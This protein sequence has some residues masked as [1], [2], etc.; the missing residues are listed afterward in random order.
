MTIPLISI[1]C[2][3][4]NHAPFI[5]Q[6]L[7][8]FVMQKTNFPIEVLIHD[9]A[10][11]DGTA[12]IIREYEQK[13]PDIIKPIY[14]TENQYSKGISPSRIY[15][16][17]RIQGKYIAICE[18]DD[19]WTDEYKLQKQVDFLEANEDYS[20]CFH[21]VKVYNEE[22]GI[23]IENDI[24]QDVPDVTDIKLLATTNYI[25]T[26]S[27]IYRNN[28]QVF[29]DL[30]KFPSLG[31]GDYI[32]HMLFA[33]Y[34]KIKK[35][36]DTMAVYRM[37]KS[38]VWSSK[39]PEYT[40]SI[41]LRVLVAL[42]YHFIN[43]QEICSILIEQYKRVSI[44]GT[45]AF[46]KNYSSTGTIYFNTGNGYSEDEKESFSVIG[47][48]VE[49]SCQIPENT[50][51][52]RL[53]PV[54]N[55]GCVVSNLEILSRNGMVKHSAI[56]GFTDK[57]GDMVFVN[58]D[59][60]IELQ[61]VGQLL[62]IRYRIQLLSDFSF[63]RVLN[64][65]ID[66]RQERDDLTAERDGLII[67]RNNLTAERDG[68]LNSR[69]WRITKPLRKF[70]AFIRKNRVL[71]L[72]AKGLLSLKRN[73]IKKTLKKGTAYRQRQ[74]GIQPAIS[75]VSVAN[76]AESERLSQENEKFSKQIKISIITPLYNTPERFLREMIE[77]V[78]AQTYGNW[79]L[80][81]A[82][83][84][85]NEHENVKRICQDYAKKEKRIKYR[86][87]EE[88]HGISGNS[89]IAIEMSSG[90]YIGLLDHD[91]VL[92]PSALYEVMK[93]ICHENADFIYTDEATF[94]NDKITLR[95][96][97]PDYAID[98]LRSC[99]YICHFSVFSRNLMEQAGTF[100]SE[101]DGSQDYDLIF[102]YTDIASAIVHIPKLLY[103]W[104]SHENSAASDINTK[105]YAI[106]AGK[107][108][109]MEHLAKLGI[110]AKVES[111]IESSGFY[112]IIY[113][114]TGR[115]LVSIIIPN[116][117]NVSLLKKCLCSIMEKTTYD[118][119]EIVIVENNSTEDATF[120]YYEELRQ[121]NN[122]HVVYWEGKGFS[123]SELNNFGVQY[124][125]GEQLIL[126]N[127]DI[128]IITPNWI[129]EMLM[130]SQRNDVGAV[131]N[132]LYY[133][134]D[135]IQHAGVI[136]GV[137]GLAGHIYRDSPRDAVGFMARLRIVQNMSVVTAACIMIKRSVFEEVGQFSS[138]FPASFNDVDLCLKIRCLGYLIVWTPYSEA[139]HYE[140][141]TRGYPDTPEKQHV[142]AQEV[143]LFKEKW[144]KEIDEGDPYYNCNY[145]LERA[146]YYLK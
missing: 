1:S 40:H 48:E 91:D 2:I 59:P 133:P 135:T 51:A 70:T 10:S 17:P 96:H 34:G 87:L 128:E 117:D 18:G 138:E 36:R 118:N 115:P 72:F 28:Q 44:P 37:H 45:D 132:K 73:G 126:L 43:N 60:Q 23:F 38:G 64:N 79:E 136:L 41:W 16:F 58:I 107:K 52:I 56:N 98:T 86:K 124:A 106:T 131:G 14:Q 63:Y 76:L 88:N 49:I 90:E 61:G 145:S 75:F 6:C 143:A 80:C 27:V 68:L 11:T 141:K 93:S 35:L 137:H 20:I 54:E 53:D 39:P 32:F 12:D 67:E 46:I 120:A 13:Y 84:S 65:Y 140:S 42:I 69:S 139:Y 103:F 94:T 109:V 134:N 5:R 127:N 74:K 25:N 19:Y 95:H 85:D 123:H 21:P 7:D 97:K 50:V 125:K 108:A 3:T 121:Y 78:I 130:Y 29:D 122:I 22:E 71:C 15:N 8:G 33:Q 24:V 30:N 81:L 113:D 110:S 55:Y 116:K 101:F 100:R 83:G 146:D 62:K 82:D 129:E 104:R 114:L 26:P 112:K 77:S 57:N 142:F 31:I 105:S 119:Y 92:H 66:T 111:A 4:Y 102:R 9:D 99:N 144:A 47:N 89:N